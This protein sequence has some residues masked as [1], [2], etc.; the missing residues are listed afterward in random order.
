MGGVN[1]ADFIRAFTLALSDDYI[2]QKPESVICGSL[3]HDISGLDESN[4][5]LRSELKKFQ[6]TNRQLQRRYMNYAILSR[7]KIKGSQV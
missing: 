1:K 4:K 7:R 2:I 6:E 5:L 3:R